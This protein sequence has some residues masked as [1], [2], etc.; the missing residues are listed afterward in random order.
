MPSVLLFNKPFQVMS[1]FT[2]DQGR[3]TLSDFINI[4]GVYAAGRLDYDSEGLMLLT[5]DGPLQNLIASPAFKLPKTYLVQVDGE[6]T[7]E[8]V[9]T[10]SGGVILKDGLTLPAIA[11]RIEPPDLWERNPPVRFRANIPTSWIRLTITEG[12][13]R[14]VRRMTAAVGF[15]T[16]RLVREAIG[17]WS[18]HHLNSGES[19]LIELSS[20][21]IVEIFPQGISPASGHKRSSR[22]THDN[23]SHR[24]YRSGAARKAANGSGARKQSN[25]GMESAGRARRS[26]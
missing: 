17:P 14:Q 18:I 10:L 16:L 12:R 7:E 6:I 20:T 23:S 4:K 22:S 26:R 3:A 19:Q 9:K 5:S 1:Q 15:P 2:D 8:A 11:E 13:N 21:Q 25:S 24:R